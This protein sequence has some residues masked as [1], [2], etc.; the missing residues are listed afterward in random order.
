MIA[1]ARVSTT[2]PTATELRGIINIKP[3]TLDD[4]SWLPAS[5]ATT[6][7][8]HARS[9]G[10]SSRPK[11]SGTNGIHLVLPLSQDHF[12]LIGTTGIGKS[13]AIGETPCG[14]IARGNRACYSVGYVTTSSTLPAAMPL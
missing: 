11:L 10:C 1:A 8:R 5:H 4:T 6:F 12:K 9:H 3:G 7:G 14:A 2:H 13:I